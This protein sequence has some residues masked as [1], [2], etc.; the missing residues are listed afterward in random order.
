MQPPLQPK[1][2]E[3]HPANS[4]HLSWGLRKQSPA[5]WSIQFGQDALRK[6]G[7]WWDGLLK[8]YQK[9]S[10]ICVRYQYLSISI[11]QWQ[12][13]SFFSIFENLARILRCSMQLFYHL[14]LMVNSLQF[15]DSVGWGGHWDAQTVGLV[16]LNPAS[17][18]QSVVIKSPGSSQSAGKE[19][20]PNPLQSTLGCALVG[21]ATLLCG[22]SYQTFKVS[23]LSASA[24]SRAIRIASGKVKDCLHIVCL[25]NNMIIHTQ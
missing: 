1:Q 14:F 7:I 6:G 3:N 12:Q 2:R 25:K 15:R 24:P 21:F 23:L 5:L 19:C 18:C 4:N 13:H 8:R 17:C 9:G 11:N 16:T 22:A 10:L 20:I